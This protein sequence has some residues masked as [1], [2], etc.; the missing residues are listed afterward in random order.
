MLEALHGD[1]IEIVSPTFMNQ[2]VFDPNRKFMFVPKPQAPEPEQS[3][4][5][6]DIIFDKAEELES[7]ETLKQRKKD[8]QARVAAVKELIGKK[9][10]TE[11]Q[12]KELESLSHK[13]ERFNTLIAKKEQRLEQEV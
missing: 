2:R 6:E 10:P 5:P 8:Y 12:K 11:E 9:E 13:V 1:G 4:G 7:I 3:A